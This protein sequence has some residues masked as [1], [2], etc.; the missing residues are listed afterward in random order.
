VGASAFEAAL[1]LAALRLTRERVSEEPAGFGTVHDEARGP[2]RSVT[3]RARGD[4]SGRLRAG[5]IGRA[6]GERGA[7]MFRDARP[8]GLA[9]ERRPAG[10]RDVP[11]ADAGD[12]AAAQR[13]DESSGADSEDA[14]SEHQS[15][16]EDQETMFLPPAP[17]HARVR[18]DYPR[19]G[20]MSSLH[21]R[22]R[23][24]YLGGV[25]LAAGV[26]AAAA[27]AC[28]DDARET[29]PSNGPLADA[30]VPDGASPGDAGAA[31]E[32]KLERAALV[33][34]KVYHLD[35]KGKLV[36]APNVRVCIHSRAD[37]PCVTTDAEGTY[38]HQ[39]V[40]E[41]DTAISFTKPGYASTLWLRVIT[42]G[43]GQTFE[44]L[45][46]RD[47]DNSALFSAAG[48]TYP[49]SGY[50]LVTMND[51]QD[52]DGIVVEPL[53]AATEGPLYSA[54]GTKIDR[55]AGGSLGDGII[56]TIAP[57][58]TL[59]LRLRGPDGGA[60][61]Q[62]LGGWSSVDSTITVPVLEDTETS[63]LVRCK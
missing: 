7:A 57:V 62:E 24:M 10:R 59:K 44:A 17:S 37:L 33:T 61:Q 16:G 3:G 55:D 38:E 12:L 36:A 35:D 11:I 49:K 19:G 39:C 8:A 22:N 1:A 14:C 46:V 41:G 31:A 23:W 42:A 5:G 27:T 52:T 30:A 40:P 13:G 6:R 58:G 47:A 50:G 21:V 54:S 2:T 63:V 29:S 53:D 15:H 60:C 51:T 26:D 28:T 18:G 45:V 56:F 9:G 4:A 48:A 43:F 34:G 32:C 20:R 25:A